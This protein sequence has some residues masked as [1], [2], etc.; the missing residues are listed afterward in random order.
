MLTVPDNAH[1]LWEALHATVE[2]GTNISV[3]HDYI[4]M[5]TYYCRFC[6]TYNGVS[7]S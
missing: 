7:W 2:Q 1:V 5:F 3:H 6:Y 4:N